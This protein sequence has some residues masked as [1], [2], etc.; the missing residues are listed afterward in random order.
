MSLK[1]FK[2]ERLPKENIEKIKNYEKEV[3]N[4]GEIKLYLSIDSFTNLE[5]NLFYFE[6]QHDFKN[7]YAHRGS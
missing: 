5:E 3:G 4:I 6:F 1:I 7:S 2:I